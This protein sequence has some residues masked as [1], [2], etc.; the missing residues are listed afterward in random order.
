MPVRF[1]N[2]PD[3]I[4]S[5]R[6]SQHLPGNIVVDWLAVD[7]YLKD[8]FLIGADP[9][10]AP[11]NRQLYELRSQGQIPNNLPAG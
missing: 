1:H 6:E 8:N 10:V 5:G 4:R 2:N 9:G 7:R 11:G 3:A